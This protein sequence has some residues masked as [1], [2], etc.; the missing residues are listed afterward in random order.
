LAKNALN[1]Q[2]KPYIWFAALTDAR[3]ALIFPLLPP[4]IAAVL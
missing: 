1:F 3:L 4:P 2:K